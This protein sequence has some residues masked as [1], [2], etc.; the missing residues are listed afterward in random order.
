MT[1]GEVPRLISLNMIKLWLINPGLTLAML[2]YQRPIDKGW[3]SHRILPGPG[4][5][6]LALA[7]RR[8]NSHCEVTEKKKNELPRDARGALDAEV[9]SDV[10]G[11]WLENPR[12]Q[13]RLEI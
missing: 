2:V 9:P 8:G 6:R 10:K 13:W 12:T 4:E 1:I 5:V 11:S 3:Y 7:S